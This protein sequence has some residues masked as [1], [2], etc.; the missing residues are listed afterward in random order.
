VGLIN[1]THYLSVFSKTSKRDS[2]EPYLMMNGDRLLIFAALSIPSITLAVSIFLGSDMYHMSGLEFCSKPVAFDVWAEVP[3]I[4]AYCWANLQ[5]LSESGEVISLWHYSYYPFILCTLT[6]L[7]FTTELMWRF[8]NLRNLAHGLDYVLDALEESIRDIMAIFLEDMTAN[9]GLRFTHVGHEG[10]CNEN[11]Q[12]K[13]SDDA[14]KQLLTNN[15]YGACSNGYNNGSVKSDTAKDG[16]HFESHISSFVANTHA[17]K[18]FDEKYTNFNAILKSFA[19]SSRFTKKLIFFRAFLFFVVL[20]VEG[21]TAWLFLIPHRN[22]SEINCPLPPQFYQTDD[23]G[24][25]I[26][27]TTFLF[28]PVVIR[29]EILWTMVICNI[30][31]AF[32]ALIFWARTPTRHSLGMCLLKQLPAV[33]MDASMISKNSDLSYLMELV[34]VNRNRL[35]YVKFGFNILA[36]SD[37]KMHT[38]SRSK[39]GFLSIFRETILWMRSLDKDKKL[40]KMVEIMNDNIES[41]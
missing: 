40:A 36:A 10:A 19:S 17:K 33:N 16:C 20:V 6:L 2:S 34:Y 12:A 41:G 38:S 8:V 21:V 37:A 39:K 25:E 18:K 35:D 14:E 4:K 24:T 7:V 9:P 3:Y 30:V 11:F 5:H 1:P 31:I 28:S 15:G 26:T 32:S 29:T 27:H 23:N 22:P 13:E